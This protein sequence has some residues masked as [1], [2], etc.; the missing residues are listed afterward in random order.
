MTHDE[1]AMFITLSN[2]HQRIDLLM[3]EN[4]RLQTEN[5][6]LKSTNKAKAHSSDPEIKGRT[7]DI[8]KENGSVVRILG[9]GEVFWQKS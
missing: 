8:I 1:L 6:T 2:L 3:A 9:D 5:D 4:S 7:I